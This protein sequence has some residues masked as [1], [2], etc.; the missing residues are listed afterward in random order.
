MNILK[1]N[2]LYSNSLIF[3]IGSAIGGI[4]SYFYN[5]LMARMLGPEGY[6]ELQAI[7][8][9]TAI[10]GIPL[11][12]VLTVI[13]KY[14]ASFK[15]RQER[16]KIFYVLK[17]FSVKMLLA[18]FLL[19]MA[20]VLAANFLVG[21]LHLTSVVPLIILAVGLV[22]AFLSTTNNGLL[23]GLQKF[24]QLSAIGITSVAIK[25][26]LAYFLVRL[27]FFVSGAVGA[28]VLSGVFGYL[29][30]WLPL[31]FLFRY[32][33]SEKF[34][35]Q[36]MWKYSVP[37]FFVFLFTTWMINLDIV[38]IKHFFDPAA[39]G[40]YAALAVIGHIIFFVIGP[41]VSVMFPMSSE[42]HSLNSNS[43][44]IFKNSISL[45]AV[46]GMIGVLFYFLIPKDR[47]ST[48]LNSSHIPLSR[49]PSS[50]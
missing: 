33:S 31:R 37:V 23:Q 17:V 40:Q 9:L 43:M 25:V 28:I 24:K 46:L 11:S 21:F 6:G 15:A 48:R 27:G 2:K 20:M 38:L 45:A 19:F 32:R 42:A 16:N 10:I 47:K 34:E 39:A 26:V 49:M 5:F 36:A 44:S 13:I 8:A 3:L 12:T 35:L 22:I 41:I 7:I 4:G 14:T 18:G 1:N 29:L 50:A 30:A